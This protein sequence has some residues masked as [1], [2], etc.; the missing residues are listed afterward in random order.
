MVYRKDIQVLR[1]ISVVLVV[2]FHLD[3]GLVSGFLGVDVFFVI[4]GF[5][6]SVLYREGQAKEFYIKRSLRLLPA[7]FTTVVLVLL[8]AGIMTTPNELRGVVNQSLFATAF[9][10]N[11]GFWLENS[12]FS[13]AEFKPLLHLWSL[14]V[15]IQFYILVP[16]IAYCHK[17]WKFFLPSMIAFTAIACFIVVGVSPKASFFLTPFR[18]WE[19][20]LGFAVASYFTDNGRPISSPQ[21]SWLGAIAFLPLVAI[22]LMV[23]DGQASGFLIGHPGMHA[24]AVCL[25]VAIVLAFGIP[26]WFSN[27][28]ISTVFETLGEYSYSIYLVHFPTIVFFMYEPF[29]GT[30]LK[31]N[32]LS[33]TAYILLIVVIA[34]L[35]MHNWIEEPFRKKTGSFNLKLSIFAVFLVISAAVIEPAV[36]KFFYSSDELVIFNASKDKS[37]F[38][39]ATIGRIQYKRELS[40]EVTN[41][42]YNPSKRL[43]RVDGSHAD[44]I[45]SQF[46]ELAKEKNVSVRFVVSND[47]LTEGGPDELAVINDAKRY[48]ISTII[49]HFH[50]GHLNSSGVNKILAL[51]KSNNLAIRIIMPVPIWDDSIPKLLWRNE[52]FSEPLPIQT[53]SQ[54]ERKNPDFQEFLS[55]VKTD[56]FIYYPVVD[57]FCKNGGNCSFSDADGKPLYYD[58]NHLTL[59]GSRVLK[60]LFR[61]VIEE[62]E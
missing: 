61:Q 6:M 21:L 62:S 17:R 27:S 39:C 54:Y 56:K 20:L 24:L 3:I 46:A 14:G 31:Q 58:S 34:S 7:Y 44:A 47:P 40:C 18:M 29:S 42:V 4:S 8:V 22:P 48:Q 57:Y 33:Q 51:A 43:V 9:S 55:S 30:L 36:E 11:I 50:P 28:R 10:P 59:T 13:K 32:N 60:E 1:G 49:L 53:A 26:K 16:L 25:S 35:I 38:R 52:K 45:K 5:L 41:G 19:L 15:E 37:S 23:V 12:Y 2:L